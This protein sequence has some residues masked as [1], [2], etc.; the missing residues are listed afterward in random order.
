VIGEPEAGLEVTR[1]SES[2]MPA[3][4]DILLSEAVRSGHA[5]ASNFHAAWRSRPFI[6]EGEALFLAWG[7][8]RLLAMAAISADPFVDDATTGRLR[9]IYV[10]QTARRQGIADRLVGDCLALARGRWRTLRLHTDNAV[11]A[12]LYERYGF[13]PSGS[14]PHATHTMAV[15]PT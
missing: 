12:R 10:R 5:W 3:C 9:F 2:E 8:K 6:S 7:G 1:W 15:T 4:L 11:A 13:Q 14:D